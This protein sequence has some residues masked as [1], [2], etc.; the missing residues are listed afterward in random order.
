MKLFVRSLFLLV[1]S[2][3][4]TGE[5]YVQPEQ[6][7]L[8]YGAEPSEMMVTWTTF[9]W[10]N[11]SMVEYG[12]GR[13]RH[14]TAGNCTK[15][16]DGGQQHRTLFI[17]RVL[18]TGLKPNTLYRYHCGNDRHGW[19]PIFWFRTMPVSTWSPVLAVYGDM[20]NVNAQSLPFLQEEA[21]NGSI[22]AVLHVGDFAYDMDTNEARVGDEFMRQIEPVAAYVPYMTCVGNH[23]NRYNFSNYVNRFSM[24]DQRSRKINNHFFSFNIGPAHVIGFSTEFYFFVNYGFEQ[25][26]HQYQWLEEDLKEAS[27]PENRARHPWIITMGH[28][29]MYCSN[30][31]RDDC[32]FNESIV[33]KGLPIL[34]LYGLE[35][36]F[37]KYGVDL[38]L[39]AHEH[40]Y[41][42]LWPVYDRKVYNGSYDAPYTNPG[43][44]VHIVTGSAGCQERLDPFVPHPRPWSA[45]RI[46]DYGYSRMTLH[47]A[48]HLTLEQLSAEKE[49][50][51]LDKITIEKA[52]HG[53][54]V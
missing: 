4:T 7:H 31:D 22:H 41:E 19:S 21:Q 3:V 1:L 37:H 18:L 28:R 43:A 40:S 2:S 10:T 53:P 38:E 26:A 8:S 5:I 17:H 52:S 25:I 6:V 44:P 20:G 48:T 46:S 39:W 51:I 34:H 24:I 32:T 16:T 23:E 50:Q 12:V 33:R 30:N 15:F 35:D 9:N 27:K 42:R 14:R 11:E 29:P 49:G 13:P 45:V 54:Y 36:L 47:N